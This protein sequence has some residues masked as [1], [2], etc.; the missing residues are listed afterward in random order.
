M[1]LLKMVF[2][3][4]ASILIYDLPHQTPASFAETPDKVIAINPDRL[5][6]FNYA[7][8]PK[9]FKTQRQTKALDIPSAEN[10]LQILQQS[11]EQLNQAG[12]ILYRHGSLCQI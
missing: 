3:Q 9:L 12:Y 1:L 2:D 8:M 6:V 4:F 11:I 7:H 10:K 5:S